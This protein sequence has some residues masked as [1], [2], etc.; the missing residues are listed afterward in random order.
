MAETLI[1]DSEVLNALA[2]PTERRILAERARAV[3]TIAHEKRAL[4][5]VP[6]PVLSETCRGPRYD[7][8][9]NRLLNAR[10][11]GICNLTR[12]I[13]QQAGHLLA[14]RKLS[15]AHAVDAFVV[16]TALQLS[17]AIIA[18]GDPDDIQR[19]ASSFKQVRVLP[20]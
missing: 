14:K 3:L 11:I 7:A 20:L 19:L 2:R 15:S 16:A 12:S 4:V 1:L 18:T 8:A 13:A 17:P 6:A 10:G 5:R 9:I